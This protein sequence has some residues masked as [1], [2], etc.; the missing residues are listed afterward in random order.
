M[1]LVIGSIEGEV[2]E[3]RRSSPRSGTE[4]AS[5]R[6]QV[7]QLDLVGSRPL[8]DPGVGLVRQVREKLSSMM[9]VRSSYGK[10]AGDTA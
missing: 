4:P 3:L 2:A 6:R 9:A 5:V 10:G 1:V 8:A 7:G